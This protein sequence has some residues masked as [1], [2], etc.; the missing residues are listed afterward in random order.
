MK[1]E[2][3]TT[4]WGQTV[5]ISQPL[6]EYVTSGGIALP[7]DC[8]I[9]K[10]ENV[11]KRIEYEYTDLSGI[12]LADFEEEQQNNRK[13]TLRQFI[14]THGIPFLDT[15][16]EL[17]GGGFFSGV[18]IIED[19]VTFVCNNMVDWAKEFDPQNGSVLME[20]RYKALKLAYR[21]CV[22]GYDKIACQP[23][24]NRKKEKRFKIVLGPDGLSFLVFGGS[25][26]NLY[27]EADFLT[28]IGPDYEDNRIVPEIV[29]LS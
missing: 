12:R 1:K 28:I 21:V 7:R 29:F 13:E 14:K 5:E 4:S 19:G 11:G 9:I 24:M 6:S 26:L 25:L 16:K 15:A 20:A 10:A 23:D 3:L 22:F 17:T 2:T 18:P 8:G 27:P